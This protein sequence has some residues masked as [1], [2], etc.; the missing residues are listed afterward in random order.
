MGIVDWD[1]CPLNPAPAVLIEPD[2]AGGSLFGESPCLEEDENLA[3]GVG[4]ELEEDAL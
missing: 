3:I 1:R 2:A 4:G